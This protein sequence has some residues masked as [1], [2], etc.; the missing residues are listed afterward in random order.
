MYHYTECGLRNVWL[1]NGYVIHKTPY[2][3]GVSI[4]DVEGLHEL[5]GRKLAMLP[6]LTGTELRFLRKEMGMSQRA[7]GEL[8]GTSEQNISLWERRGRMPKVSDRLVRLIY[9]EHLDGN[10]RVRKIIENLN[11]LDSVKEQALQFE[12]YS[13]QWKEAA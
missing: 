9:L 13:G 5:I 1:K 2:G 3:E 7:L 12:E 8:L 10:V 11:E 6:K 4:Q